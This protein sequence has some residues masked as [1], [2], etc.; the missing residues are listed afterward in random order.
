MKVCKEENEMQ[1]HLL[2][3][4]ILNKNEKQSIEYKKIKSGN[5]RDMTE[6]AKKFMKVLEIRA[7][8]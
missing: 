7:K 3:C 1:E 6:I 8:Q 2:T 4:K 5:V